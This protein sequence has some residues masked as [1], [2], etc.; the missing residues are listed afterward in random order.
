MAAPRTTVWNLDPHTRA[1][2][3]IL[4]RYLEAWMPI[5]SH[6]NFPKI[7]YIDGFAGPG[8]Y[9]EGEDGSPI[10]ALKTALKYQPPLRAQ[11]YFFFV[12]K[13]KERA[14]HLDSLIKN[15]EVP[16]NFIPIV[17][18]GV[19]FEDAFHRFYPE[20]AGPNDRLPPTFAFIDPFGWTGAP[21]SIVEKI[22]RHRSCEVFINFMYEE[23]NRFLVHPDQVQNFDSY[24]GTEDWQSLAN[25]SDSRERNRRLHDLYVSQLHKQAGVKFVRSFE[26]K[27]KRGVTDYYLFYATNNIVGL[28][29]MKEAMWRV[30]EGGEFA[31]S[32]ATDQNQF[33]LFEKAP[34]YGLLQRQ[35][36][37]RFR[38][39]P[40]S[41]GEIEHFVVTQT[42]FRETHY[43]KQVLAPLETDGRLSVLNPPAARG[44]G[45]FR[46]P[47]LTIL[48][49]A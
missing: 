15:M 30:D 26:M 23:I 5:L 39:H 41:R 8:E 12:E 37:S 18:G 48:I 19:T 28:K 6:G 17:N 38:G 2:H 31:F 36:I 32:D 42:A 21:F 25:I 33:V 13:D 45:T 49:K 24:F 40:V 7:L 4:E 10:I 43:K 29:K 3:E 46:D 9:S 22:M 47:N 14:S 35:I 44:K 1:K 34:N 11:I 16:R 27:N 20:F